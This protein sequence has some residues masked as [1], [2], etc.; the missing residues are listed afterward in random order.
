MRGF[1][2]DRD[3]DSFFFEGMSV[4][5]DIFNKNLQ[6]FHKGGNQLSSKEQENLKKRIEARRTILH[7]QNLENFRTAEVGRHLA[8]F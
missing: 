1:L 8:A 2:R 4:D 7:F 6:L 5:D 3:Y